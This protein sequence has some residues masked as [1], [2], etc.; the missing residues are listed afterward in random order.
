MS[1]AHRQY[2]G[3]HRL[4]DLPAE[5]VCFQT[6]AVSEICGT[7]GLWADGPTTAERREFITYKQLK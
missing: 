3:S 1:R 6:E 4:A 5:N 2:T 7:T